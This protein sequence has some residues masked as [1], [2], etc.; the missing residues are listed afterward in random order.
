MGGHSSTGRRWQSPPLSGLAKRAALHQNKVEPEFEI[1][2][3]NPS[4][5]VICCGAVEVEFYCH[6]K[7]TRYSKRLFNEADWKTQT[8]GTSS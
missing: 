6:A 5:T 8:A 2:I 7:K 3:D 4:R 1:R